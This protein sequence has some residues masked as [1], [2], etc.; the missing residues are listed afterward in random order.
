MNYNVEDLNLLKEILLSYYTQ[1]DFKIIVLSNNISDTMEVKFP[2]QTL[3]AQL[4]LT[5]VYT[6]DID[7]YCFHFLLK[8]LLEGKISKYGKGHLRHHQLLILD[9]MDGNPI[10]LKNIEITNIIQYL[11]YKL[12]KN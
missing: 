4:I 5:K 7:Y 12:F 2:N 11:Y 6:V 1:D 10:K 3:H 9:V 8:K